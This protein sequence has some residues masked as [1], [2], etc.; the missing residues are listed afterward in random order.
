M[1]L[2]IEKA[3]ELGFYLVHKAEGLVRFERVHAAGTAK[4]EGKDAD[5]AL[6]G[7]ESH[8]AQHPGAFGTDIAR[9]DGAAEPRDLQQAHS[10]QVGTA[11]PTPAA[12][13]EAA[14]AVNVEDLPEVGPAIEAPAEAAEAA[15]AESV[16]S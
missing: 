2:T 1:A 9:S 14:A 12:D 6:A 15:P 8:L 10:A 16:E 4:F 11:G 13:I 3:A 7:I 5:E